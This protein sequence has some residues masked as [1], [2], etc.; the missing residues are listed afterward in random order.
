MGGSPKLQQTGQQVQQ[1]QLPQWQVDAWQQLTGA[2]GGLAL[3]GG[4]A[5]QAT[6]Y[7][8]QLSVATPTAP[9][10]STLQSL[11]MDNANASLA[12]ARDPNSINFNN[13]YQVPDAYTGSQYSAAPVEYADT[14][15]GYN[16]QLSSF[17]IG[18]A[19]FQQPNFTSREYNFTPQQIAAERIAA[20]GRGTI[21]DVAAPTGLEAFQMNAA[22]RIGAQ[23]VREFQMQAP[24]D[25]TAGETWT[26]AFTDPGIRQ[27]YMDPYMAD[28]VEGER[29]KAREG[30]GEQLSQ[31]GSRAAAAG[32]LGGTRQA[33]VE[34]GLRRDYAN[35]LGDITAT[36]LERAYQNAQQ[37]YERDRAAS[38]GTQQFNV[39]TALEAARAN[40]AAQLASGQSNLQ[41]QLA[42]QQLGVTTGLEAAKSNQAAFLEQARANQAAQLAAQQLRATTGLEAAKAN[43][44]A[45]IAFGGMGLDAAKANQAALLEAA[46]ANQST[47][48]QGQI[49]GAELGEKSRQFGADLGLRGG[50]AQAQLQQEAAIANQRAQ[51]AA[52]ELGTTSGLEALKTRYQGGL[53]AGIANQGADIDAA[54]IREQSGQFGYQQAQ[55]AGQFGAEQDL[56]TQKAQQDAVA[57]TIRNNLAAT[58]AAS[59]TWRDVGSLDQQGFSNQIAAAGIGQEGLD[60]AYQEWLRQQNYPMSQLSAYSNMLQGLPS[61]GTTTTDIYGQ[62]PSIWG[63]IAGLGLGAASM[64]MPRVPGGGR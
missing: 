7:G 34:G 57:A 29:R 11:M 37:Q 12:N 10:Y 38:T 2:A 64:F 39:G 47:G 1:T 62:K 15:A 33:V 41:S 60:K 4:Q 6:P 9:N 55:Q 3:P 52:Q 21:R 35:Q 30:F 40:Q 51:L 42:T 19:S 61:M 44:G 5:P 8:G 53:Q 25:I 23:P 18:A 31:A 24:R 26:N 63:Q 59:N 22:E 28:V 17:G 58:E 50:L 49:A 56:A 43:Q 36:G 46:R 48:L 27:Q 45:D 32:A 20:P 14:L 54:R 13:S 16:P